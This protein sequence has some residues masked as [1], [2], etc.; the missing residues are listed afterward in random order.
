MAATFLRFHI[1]LRESFTFYYIL[2][3]QQKVLKL[4]L[5][6]LESYIKI[7]CYFLLCYDAHILAS[8]RLSS[9]KSLTYNS[10]TE[11]SGSNF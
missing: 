5:F 9:G 7:F 3:G 10:F 2:L 11:N 1:L 8:I 4:Y 6:T